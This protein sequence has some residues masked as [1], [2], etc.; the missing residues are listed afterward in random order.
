MLARK[1]PDDTVEAIAKRLALYESQTRPL[2]D[3]FD[4]RELL[5]T[6]DGMGSQDD[7]FC[8]LRGHL[9]GLG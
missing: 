1:R 5:V 4:E 6:V 8:R 7:V 2:L 3:W 9:D